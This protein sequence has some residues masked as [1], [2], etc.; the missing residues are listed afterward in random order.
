MATLAYDLLRHD[1]MHDTLQPGQK[2]GIDVVAER[3]G[4]GVS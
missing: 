1:I 4:V 3:Y 2:L